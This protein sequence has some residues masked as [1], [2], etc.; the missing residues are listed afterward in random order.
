MPPALAAGAAGLAAGAGAGAA[1]AAGAAA[2]AGAASAGVASSSF[3][4]YIS[5]VTFSASTDSISE[6]ALTA[7][8]IGSNSASVDKINE[9]SNSNFSSSISEE[10]GSKAIIVPKSSTALNTRKALAAL[11]KHSLLIWIVNPYNCFS[12]FNFSIASGSSLICLNNGPSAASDDASAAGSADS[13]G[14][15]SAGASPPSACVR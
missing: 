3:F 10:L 1:G 4:S 8:R 6:T 12:P 5:G 7:S 2:S 13:A 11:S 14:A 9:K 15:A